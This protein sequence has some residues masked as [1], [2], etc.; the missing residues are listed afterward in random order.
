MAHLSI[1][2]LGP[3]RVS[4]DGAPL[5]HFDSDKAR[6]LLAYLA[7][8]GH[9]PY[10]RE[11]LAGLL[12][13]GYPE[14]SARRSLSQ[15]LFGLRR[16]LGLAG[17]GYPRIQ[18]DCKTVTFCCD[19]CEV[20]AAEL[21][22][23]VSACRSHGHARA[24]E[25]PECLARYERAAA[26]YAGE[27]MAGFSLPDSPE[28]EEWL[29]LKREQCRRQAVSALEALSAQG[30]EHGD[31][32]AA[33]RTARRW[34]ELEPLDERAHRQVMRLLAVTGQSSA[35]LA[36][37][38]ACRRMLRAELGA[39][40]DARTTALYERIH[41]G[42]FP[43]RAARPD[44]LAVRPPP[45]VAQEV[46]GHPPLFVARE[47]ELA[48]LQRYLD[49]M[50][51]GRA[52][53]AFV[54]GEAGCGKT[55]L[56]QELARRAQH[57]HPDLI[58]ATG[59]CNAFTGIGDPYL[60]FREILA[61]LGGEI[62]GAWRAGAIGQ[63]EAFRLWALLPHT[64][65]ALAEAGPDLVGVL[66]DGEGLLARAEA[67]ASPDAS[68]AGRLR[69]LVA[70]RR[71]VPPAGAQQPALFQQVTAVLQRL[72][73][74][75]PLVLILED[76]HWADAA[77]LSLL[78]HLGAHLAAD[79]VLIVGTFRPVGLAESRAG[80]TSDGRHPL[81][82]VLNEF[83]R[84]YGEII[85][86]LER[87]D[88]R[89]LIDAL[90]D[91][92]PNVLDGGFRQALYSQS[93]GNALFATEL[94]LALRERSELR[95]GTD[96]RWTATG[97]EDW[98]R[99]PVRVEGV[100]AERIGR[101]PA[102]LQETL[103]AASVEGETFTVEVLSRVLDREPQGVVRWLSRDL[104]RTQQL[105]SPLEAQRAGTAALGRYRFRHILVQNYVYGTLDAVERAYLHRAVAEAIEAIA[106]ED[107]D[108]EV[109]VLARHYEEAGDP[110]TA[111][112]NLLRAGDRAMRLVAFAEAEELYSRGLEQLE[113]VPQDRSRDAA[114][115]ALLL[116]LGNARGLNAGFADPQLA[117][118]ARR[119]LAVA[120]RLQDDLSSYRALAVLLNYHI[121]A[122]AFG[123]ANAEGDRMLALARSLQDED[124]AAWARNLC[125]WMRVF[126]GQFAAAVRD[127]EPILALWK[128]GGL[129]SLRA[130]LNQRQLSMSRSLVTIV[131]ALVPMGLYGRALAYLDDALELGR[132]A[133]P[134]IDQ[135][136]V[137][138]LAAFFY[139]ET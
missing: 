65:L 47:E 9:S 99:L 74:V 37:Y 126:S 17:D 116:R 139:C 104:G 83:Q 18:G 59:R 32:R 130:K 121:E 101:L 49:A 105:V 82:P 93:G 114:E 57:E 109:L 62:E 66:I 123:V 39:E 113:P 46:R 42:E 129:D 134:G 33:L 16:D 79:R 68:W 12:W 8:D 45:F 132:T 24:V 102:A 38:E 44:D 67:A 117:D 89:H 125:G 55:A 26:L 36:H 21:E 128:S 97:T 80:G 137:A 10:R 2:L 53:F 112:A 58:V 4:L 31:P 25:C 15:T 131:L 48:H 30:E 6:A 77:S 1:A 11:A 7:T 73:R 106:G 22:S 63:E 103:R 41:S 90:L 72:A 120:E 98:D 70:A 14:S 95:I 118:I 50:L 84:R 96:G 20:D 81:E 61:Q 85:V 100:L 56:V 88:G 136:F 76:L 71:G 28:Y 108:D 64:C 86:D 107:G 91:S 92:E 122:G 69:D 19:D 34:L 133:S 127:V 138:G 119:A 5:A 40:P 27:F 54:T 60:A 29:D 52:Q 35:A 75:H 13:P 110:A 115:L 43:P 94:L 78:F 3:I 87:A 111:S 51:A 135:C 23:L 124:L